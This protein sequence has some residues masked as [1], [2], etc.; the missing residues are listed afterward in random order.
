MRASLMP[1]VIVLG[2]LGA[3]AEALTSSSTVKPSEIRYAD[4]GLTN[5]SLGAYLQMRT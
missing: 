4:I 3:H 5:G 1:Q 2:N